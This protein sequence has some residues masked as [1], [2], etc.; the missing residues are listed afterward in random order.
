MAAGRTHYFWDR[1]ANE[2]RGDW[3]EY[4]PV[5]GAKQ[6]GPYLQG[7]IKPYRNVAVDG[8]EISSRSTH[9][10]MLRANNLIEVGNERL[11]SRKAVPLPDV[12]PDIK[13]AMDQLR[14]K[15]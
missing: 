9:R 10:E 5:R 8:A 7:D 3:A 11:P 14:S 15:A 4:V 1:S 12:A 2:G 13:R 6:V